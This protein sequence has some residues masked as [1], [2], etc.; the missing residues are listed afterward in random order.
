MTDSRFIT[1]AVTAITTDRNTARISSMDST[2]TTA[3]TQGS[4]VP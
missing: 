4:R 1:A 2:T 3:I